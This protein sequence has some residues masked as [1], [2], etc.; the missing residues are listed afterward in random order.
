M[1]VLFGGFASLLLL[2]VL[3][4]GAFAGSGSAPAPTATPTLH[5]D[6]TELVQAVLSDAAI[7]L[8][9]A[10]RGD[11]ES[12]RI[13]PRVL[14]VLL[15]LTQVHELAPVGPLIT[16]HSYFVKGT[17]R[18]SNH[19]FGGAVDILG[20]DGEPVSPA[21]AA[22]RQVIEELLS[23]PAP[24]TPDEVGGPWI[25]RVGAR[26]SFTNSDHQ[27]HVHIGWDS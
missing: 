16:G 13:D 12:G 7:H 3:V 15:V 1:K 19:V 20:I 23:L 14:E 4:I 25:V 17:T 11:V 9:E 5:G 8:T 24:L 10:A 2:P 26:S 21:N 22:A 27:D 18:V 6:Q